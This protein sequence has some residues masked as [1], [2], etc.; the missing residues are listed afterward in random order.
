MCLGV[1]KTLYENILI[2]YPRGPAACTAVGC[3][4]VARK[5]CLVWQGLLKHTKSHVAVNGTLICVS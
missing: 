3:F 1:R 5:S 4:Q 2:C